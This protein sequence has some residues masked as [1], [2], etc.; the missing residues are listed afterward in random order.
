MLTHL[1]GQTYVLAGPVNIGLYFH[2]DG[3]A[4]VI[5]T[6]LDDDSGRRLLKALREKGATIGHL[7]NTHSHADHSGG[8][9]FVQKRTEAITWA[10]PLEAALIENPYL[11]PFYLYGGDPF[12]ELKTKFLMAK[13]SRVDK[14]LSE[15][16]PE[17]EP[18]KIIPLPGHAPGQIG[19]LTPDNVF[20]C[21]DAFFPLAT[22]DKYYLPY[23]AQ[24]GPSL[25]TLDRL[26][27]FP[28]EIYVPAHGHPSAE[29]TE[30]LKANKQRLQEVTELVLS[31]L[32]EPLSREEIVAHFCREKSIDSSYS[33]YFLATAAITAHLTYLDE[34][35]LIKPKVAAGVL[36][37]H[38]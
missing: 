3:R 23:F 30:A 36:K 14:K 38:R 34:Q 17:L 21:A 12:A 32:T 7:I 28:A 8:N 31:I 16:N 26:M 5:D 18:L 29:I 37:W 22:L 19:V 4:T 13:P 15:D 24:V 11:E 33:Q 25:A 20:F 10:S 2:N 1:K 6:G 9:A 35:G 27:S